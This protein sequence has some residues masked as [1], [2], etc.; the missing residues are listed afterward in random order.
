[1]SDSEETESCD[2]EVVPLR[3]DHDIPGPNDSEEAFEA[4][5]VVKG[6]RSVVY[7]RK[8]LSCRMSP[9]GGVHPKPLPNLFSIVRKKVTMMQGTLVKEGPTQMC[10]AKTLR[11]WRL[12]MKPSERLS[13]RNHRSCLTFF[14]PELTC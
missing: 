4:K 12:L 10:L 11:I 13:T 2:T 14:S 9:P 7:P 5:L 1:M 8:A 3:E 6:N